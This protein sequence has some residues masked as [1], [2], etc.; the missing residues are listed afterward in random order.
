[1]VNKTPPER[2]AST[3]KWQAKNKEKINAR[4][5]ERVRNNPDLRKK[6]NEQTKRW[7]E[8]NR[9]KYLLGKK[10]CLIKRQ[11]GLSYEDYCNLLK[12]QNGKCAICDV[13]GEKIKGKELCIDH[14]HT[15]GKVRGLL[16][17][18]CNRGI[19]LMK[20]NVLIF[21]KA[22]KYIQKNV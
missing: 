11:Y 8:N 14:N 22:I 17:H 13:V 4:I 16:C 5:R 21:K 20:D 15:T 9:E 2:L 12:K 1:M 19:G 10:I 3:R 18:S 7:R 6:R